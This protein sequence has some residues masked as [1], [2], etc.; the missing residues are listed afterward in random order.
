MIVPI[1]E[2]AASFIAGITTMPIIVE[3]YAYFKKLWLQRKHTEQI[4][5]MNQAHQ[6]RM[7]H[8]GEE[9]IT[10]VEKYNKKMTKIER[11]LSKHNLFVDI[12]EEGNEIITRRVPVD[13]S[14]RRWLKQ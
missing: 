5:R 9:W 10:A 12:D 6:A 13:M 8:L 2:V 7:K 3:G 4:R 11:K 14:F 1:V